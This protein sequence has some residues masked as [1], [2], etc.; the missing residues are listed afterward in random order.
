M[1]KKWT[2]VLI[3]TMLGVLA[4]CT[5]VTAPKRDDSACRGISISSGR[6]C[7]Q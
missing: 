6:S 5:Q 4:A 2:L 7:D 3:G 1:S